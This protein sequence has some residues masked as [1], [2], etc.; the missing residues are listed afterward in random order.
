M[1]R[2][3]SSPR[4]QRSNKIC[5]SGLSGWRK[6]ILL[7]IMGFALLAIP[8]SRLDA[9]SPSSTF[10][11]QINA[12]I[13]SG[14][15]PLAL[16]LA[17]KLG[18]G[19]SDAAM[20]RIAHA[21][22][23]S[24]ARGPAFRSAGQINNDVDR[25][26][27]LYAFSNYGS[28][29]SGDSLL[30]GGGFGSPTNSPRGNRGGITEADFEP[31]IELI[32]SVISPD[33]W[34]DTNGDGTIQAY[35]SGVYVDSTGLLKKLRVD[36][37]L[38]LKKL[39]DNARIDSGNRKS[40]FP[41]KLRKVSITRLEREAQL[42]A[43]QGLAAD[44]DMQN[45]A[46]IYEI[47]YLMVFPETGDIVVA[48]PAGP[49]IEDNEGRLVNED[50]GKPVL[51]LDDL[52]VCLRNAWGNNGK[53]GCAITPRE[54]NLA[55]TKKVLSTSKLK[56]KAWRNQLR[57]TLGR[58]DVEVFGIDPQTH[59]GRVL[60]EADYRMKLVGMGL[61]KSVP[62]VPS[63]LARIQLQADGTLPPLDVV[64]WWFTLNY[65]DVVTD[66]DRETFTFTG[67]GVK[68]LSENEMIDDVGRRIHTGQS[69]GPTREFAR[70]FTKHFEK[71]ADAY[72]VYNQLKNVFDLALVSSIVRHQGLA[73]R[74]D[75]NLTYFGEAKNDRLSYQPQLEHTATEVNS[76][77]NHRVISQRKKSS[78]VK[79]TV[80][81]ISGGI[82]FDAH[83]VISA[84][85]LAT[86]RDGVL[87]RKSKEARPDNSIGNWWW[88]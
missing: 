27:V 33:S 70:D 61:E 80:V 71:I 53:F 8:A 4:G 28:P 25:S 12:H 7:S 1:Q 67:T 85:V 43:A 24:G 76:V 30:G 11:Q 40:N 49:W 13:Q 66:K 47:E 54:S 75:W 77:M 84:D 18:P 3:F 74:V 20:K 57:T 56:G 21:Q 59:A 23:T 87:D 52:V 10:E 82:R 6:L 15:F 19:E 58:Q 44:E 83:E 36:S 69:D 48:G 42:R 81:G 73:D 9:Q 46:G 65:D 16:E 68:V 39:R 14:E 63:Y 55:E 50:T 72:P 26:Q 86:D 38:A 29:E 78:T 2:Y 34:D 5:S 64:R 17:K 32:R 79:H 45:L 35:P 41:S 88:D 22:F 62:E 51:K 60:V 31:L 37:P